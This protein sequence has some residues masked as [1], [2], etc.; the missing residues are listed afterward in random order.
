MIGY[1]TCSI[2]DISVW[3]ILTFSGFRQWFCYN[4]KAD[5]HVSNWNPHLSVLKFIMIV[6]FLCISLVKTKCFLKCV[7]EI[8]WI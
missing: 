3:I 2:V 6:K 1:R 8:A 5:H 4:V 7:F